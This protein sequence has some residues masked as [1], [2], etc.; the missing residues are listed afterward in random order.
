VKALA[1]EAGYFVAGIAL[2][3]VWSVFA[4][5][6]LVVQ[7]VIADAWFDFLA[8]LVGLPSW[9]EH[10]FGRSRRR[11]DAEPELVLRLAP[12]PHRVRLARRDRGRYA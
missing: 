6:V 2:F 12:G 3:V 9:R 10:G 11:S 7:P 4:Y 5:G 1:I 8:W